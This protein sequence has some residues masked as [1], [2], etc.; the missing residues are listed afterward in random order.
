MFGLFVAVCVTSSCILYAC[1]FWFRFCALA[2]HMQDL[3]C[4]LAEFFFFLLLLLGCW[5][6]TGVKL[7]VAVY[8]GVGGG[9]SQCVNIVCLP[10]CLK[11]TVQTISPI[12]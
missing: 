9:V 2:V 1:V 7:K 6:E 5:N 12:L 3:Y 4:Q 10:S 8:A 11:K